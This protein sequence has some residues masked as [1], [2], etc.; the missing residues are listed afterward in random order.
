MTEYLFSPP[1]GKD[2]IPFQEEGIISAHHILTDEQGDQAVDLQYEMGLGKSVVSMALAGLLFEDDLIDHVLVVAEANK[3]RDWAEDDFPSWTSLSVLRYAGTKAQR[4]RMRKDLPQVIVMT[5]ET[6]REDIAVFKHAKKSQGY[7]ITGPG[8]LAEALKGK[9]VLVVFDEVTKLRSRDSRTHIAWNYLVNRWLRRRKDSSCMAMGL[10]GTKIESSPQDHYNVNRILAP[11][12]S[13]LVKDFEAVYVDEVDE[14]SSKPLSWKNLDQA[15]CEPG[16][17]PLSRLYESITLRKRKHDPDV[18]GW[19]P[20]KVENPSRFI[21]MTP[22]QRT[23]YEDVIEAL[24]DEDV[25]AGL[26]VLRQIAAHPMSLTLSQGSTAQAIVEAVGEPNLLA[27]GSAK[28]EAMLDWLRE[29]GDQQ[30]VIF[31]F[32]GQSVLPLLADR[33]RSE[34]FSVVVNHGQMSSGERQQAQRTFKGGDAQVFLSSDAGARGLNLGVGSV[35]LHYDLPLLYSIYSQRSDRIHRADSVH[36][37]VTVDSLLAAGTVE[38]GIFDL[39]MK[40]NRWSD[41]VL[42]DRDA[43]DEI[44]GGGYLTAADRRRLWDQARRLG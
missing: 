32:F 35:L 6:G 38:E 1:P 27:A 23:L 13:P 3:V 40:R 2:L 14:W 26:T 24:D 28:T 9:R 39:V 19:F 10:T 7:A 43:G 16:V 12:L 25:M 20:A 18:I 11:G 15:T 5:Y 33:L 30:A 17:V 21:P 42:D 29:A 34:N 4:E 31:T 36:P 22:R 37:S 44:V 41:Q 8:P